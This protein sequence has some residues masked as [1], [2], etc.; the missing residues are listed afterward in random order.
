M[1]GLAGVLA[2]VYFNSQYFVSEGVQVCRV[3]FL[4]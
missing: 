3:C 2:S 1:V 4:L